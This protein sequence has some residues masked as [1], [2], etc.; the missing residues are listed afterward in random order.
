VLVCVQDQTGRGMFSTPFGIAVDEVSRPNRC[1]CALACTDNTS[2]SCVHGPLSARV[3]THSRV[4]PQSTVYVANSCSHC[5]V[6]LDKRTSR[7]V[8]TLGT[9][10][11]AGGGHEQLSAPW[12]VGV[13]DRMVYVADQVGASRRPAPSSRLGVQP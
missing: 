5:V 13:D 10:N 12:G 2:D 11:Q 9:L 1:R 6:I 3:I 4:L 7:R 8:R